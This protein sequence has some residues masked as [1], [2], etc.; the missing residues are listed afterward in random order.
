MRDKIKTVNRTIH[1][2]T[3][4]SANSYRVKIGK[5]DYYEKLIVNINHEKSDYQETFVFDG[6]E[7]KNYESIHF[8]ATENKDTVQIQWVQNLKFTKG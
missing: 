3:H 5:R 2:D 8:K 7:I 4:D 1:P 6:S